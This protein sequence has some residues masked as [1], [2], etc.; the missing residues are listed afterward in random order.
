M[1]FTQALAERDQRYFVIELLSTCPLNHDLLA[2][3]RIFLK[4]V[5][6]SP[7][8]I[9]VHSTSSG[10]LR[11]TISRIG[12]WKVLDLEAMGTVSH[13]GQSRTQR[14][15]VL[16]WNPGVD[17]HYRDPDLEQAFDV[18]QEV[19]SVPGVIIP[20]ASPIHK[21]SDHEECW[22]IAKT[23]FDDCVWGH[24]S[25]ICGTNSTPSLPRRVLDV[26][27]A[28]LRLFE[29]KNGTKRHWVALSHCWGNTNTFKTTLDTLEPFKRGIDWEALPKTLKDAVKVT[30]ALGVDY[31]WIDSLC[32]IQDD[33]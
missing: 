6:I 30:R 10:H 27:N 20:T 26:K 29:P 16:H 23:W 17:D 1:C 8:R 12:F 2:A 25:C 33:G 24:A 3:I 7:D 19:Q 9:A 21:T 5:D 11:L 14:L 22:T 15:E 13:L 4:Q 28:Q 32:I 31:L 18:Y